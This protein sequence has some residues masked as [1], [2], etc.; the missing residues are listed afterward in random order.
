MIKSIIL[1]LTLLV[2]TH[3]VLCLDKI[4]RRMKLRPKANTFNNIGD[5]SSK[6]LAIAAYTD[7]IFPNAEILKYKNLEYIYI[8][9][10]RNNKDFIDDSTAHTN[11]IKIEALLLSSLKNLAC[12]EIEGTVIT[13]SLDELFNLKQLKGIALNSCGIRDVQLEKISS[14]TCEYLDLSSNFISSTNF[15][16]SSNFPNLKHLFMGFNDVS[17]FKS[18]GLN[19]IEEISLSNSAIGPFQIFDDPNWPLDTLLDYSSWPKSESNKFELMNVQLALDSLISNNNV[20]SVSISYSAESDFANY[21]KVIMKKSL[22]ERLR[23]RKLR[24]RFD[25]IEST[26]RILDGDRIPLLILFFNMF[27]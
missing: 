19:Y 10:E 9:F 11:A 21:T 27:Y 3:D 7:S 4:E 22:S 6:E 12:I 14:S 17:N 8:R 13:S 25:A 16:N 15:I 26:N 1:I 24:I 2:A 23:Y 20:K 18:H 5:Y